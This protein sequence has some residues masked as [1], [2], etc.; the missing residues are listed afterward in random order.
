MALGGSRPPKR[1]GHT[2][3][4]VRKLMLSKRAVQAV[5]L[6]DGRHGFTVLPHATALASDA[7]RPHGQ[8]Q[9]VPQPLL[10][11]SGTQRPEAR[12]HTPGARAAPAEPAAR[13]DWPRPEGA[14]APPPA[15]CR[16]LA[17]GASG[18]GRLPAR[19][20]PARWGAG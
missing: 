10:L 6:P 18:H 7:L 19:L 20:V 17:P 1:R 4:A 12:P 8:Q 2:S 16:R 13:A 9:Q 3:Q 14:G 15:G 11:G 5:P